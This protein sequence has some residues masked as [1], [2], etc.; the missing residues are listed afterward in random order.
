MVAGA[1]FEPATSRLCVPLR[2]SPLPFPGFVV[3]TIPSPG[4][5]FGL[6]CLPS[7]LY[8]FPLNSVLG[9]VLPLWG[10]TEFDRLSSTLPDRGALFEPCELP[11]CSTPR[12]DNSKYFQA[13]SMIV[14]KDGF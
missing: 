7:S 9:S 14:E 5:D 12:S 2:L 11:G 1:G 10:F 6:G 3:W 8:T 13:K 4:R